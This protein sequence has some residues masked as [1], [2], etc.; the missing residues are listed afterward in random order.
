MSSRPEHGAGRNVCAYARARLQVGRCGGMAPRNH[1]AA[2]HG[3]HDLRPHGTGRGRF[4][5]GR[6]HVGRERTLAASS[7]RRSAA[8]PPAA[9][10]SPPGRKHPETIHP[11]HTTATR[12]GARAPAPLVRDSMGCIE[13]HRIFGAIRTL[14][15]KRTV[16]RAMVQLYGTKFQ[17]F[18][19][20]DAKT[21][22]DPRQGK[23]DLINGTTYRKTKRPRYRAGGK[24]KTCS[25]KQSRNPTCSVHL[26]E[27]TPDQG[28]GR[29][30]STRSRLDSARP[31]RRR[32]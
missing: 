2:A 13:H 1:D 31:S 17:T 11:L 26:T 4:P 15:S 5:R 16:S 21:W 25:V 27:G 28:L 6:G 10:R 12:R 8:V 22:I 29:N 7:A 23:F 30:V 3:R 14:P 18:S 20:L 24:G 19:K 9:R 32:P